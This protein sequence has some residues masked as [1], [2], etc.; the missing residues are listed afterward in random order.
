MDTSSTMPPVKSSRKPKPPITDKIAALRA[1]LAQAEA[2]AVEAEK[3][4]AAIVGAA[5]VAAMRDDPALTRQVA[6]L[7]RAKVKT[8]RDKAAIAEFLL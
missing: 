1:E 8:A 6:E 7:L 4:K 2:E 3:T 5:V